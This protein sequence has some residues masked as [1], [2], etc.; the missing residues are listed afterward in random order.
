MKNTYGTVELILDGK[1]LNYVLSATIELDKPGEEKS[2]ASIAFY[3]DYG[4]NS[5]EVLEVWDNDTYLYNTLYKNVLLPWVAEKT[6]VDG[7]EFG[8]LLQIKGVHIDDFQ[9]L[10][11]VF[12]KAIEL[13]FFNDI[14]KNGK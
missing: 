13:G 5:E 12:E 10:K 8:A 1:E 7:Q 3:K 14:I 6:V 4:L 9:E 2:M 11:E